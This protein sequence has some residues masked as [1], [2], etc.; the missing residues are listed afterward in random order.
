MKLERTVPLTTSELFR[1]A[2][3]VKLNGRAY[4]RYVR[5]LR[6]RG[7]RKTF[8]IAKDLSRSK[9]LAHRA[10]AIDVLCQLRHYNAGK[11]S[12]NSNPVYVDDSVDIICSLL[13]DTRVDILI[14]A[15]Y[16]LGHLAPPRVAGYIAR[17]CGHRDWGV[18]LA[19]AF[20]LGGD[21]SPLAIKTLIK[22][23]DDKRSQVRDWATFAIGNMAEV[24]TP[25]IREALFRKVKERSS[26]VHGEAMAGLAKRKDPRVVEYILHDLRASNPRVY[27]LDAASHYGSPVFLPELKRHL[28]A[29]QKKGAVDTYWVNSLK[30]AAKACQASVPRNRKKKI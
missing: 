4:W 15:I 28:I 7:E 29:L 2:L 24:D 3:G 20:A 6:R 11:E 21:E 27:A 18:R 10:L 1:K 17:F 9:K 5:E 23:M 13:K 19:V 8:L 22:L 12:D 16:G 26:D 14:S 30:D 25:E